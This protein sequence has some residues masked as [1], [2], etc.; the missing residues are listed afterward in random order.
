ML[1]SRFV[2]LF[3]F[4]PVF[5]FSPLCFSKG[6]GVFVEFAR[7]HLEKEYEEKLG[8]SWEKKILKNAKSWDEKESLQFLNFL[9][10]QI[11]VEDTIKR[12]KSTSYFS[13]MRFESFKERVD[14]FS[15]YIGEEGVKERLRKSLGGFHKGNIEEMKVVIE[16]I[17][18]YIGREEVRERMKQDLEASPMP[19][20]RS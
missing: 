20:W 6:G 13:N 4:L 12:I 3:F 11:G 10:D 1:F 18:G 5:L 2:I 15:G 9:K 19:S 14:F 16:F 7:W 8:Q 17:E